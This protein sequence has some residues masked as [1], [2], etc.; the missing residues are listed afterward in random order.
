MI[1]KKTSRYKTFVTRQMVKNGNKMVTD[2]NGLDSGL[3]SDTPHRSL[4]VNT[5]N[6]EL[7]V[8]RT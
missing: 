3:V 6:Y 4:R 8:F 7:R 2:G 1:F 5:T